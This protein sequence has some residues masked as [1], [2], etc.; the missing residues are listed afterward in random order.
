MA[1]MAAAKLV[2]HLLGEYLEDMDEVM[3]DVLAGCGARMQGSPLIPR[4]LARR[5]P[6]FTPEIKH[7]TRPPSSRLTRRHVLLQNLEV[8]PRAMQTALNLPLVVKAG[9]IG[10]VELRI[11]WAKLNSEPTQ[12]ILDVRLRVTR[13]SGHRLA[14]PAPSAGHILCAAYARLPDL[15]HRTCSSSADPS[16]RRRGTRRPKRP[17]SRRSSRRSPRVRSSR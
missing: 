12:L 15:P 14:S 1:G 7:R 3:I 5:A 8:K 4:Q 9:T 13:R 10:R 17:R 16:P 11:P 6:L 2:C